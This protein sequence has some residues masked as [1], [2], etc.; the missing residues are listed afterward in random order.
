M[1]C[2]VDEFGIADEYSSEEI[3]S[4]NYILSLIT[5][6]LSKIAEL[7]EAVL[8]ELAA[9][10]EPS[11]YAHLATWRV[12][13]K[14]P[15]A[16]LNLRPQTSQG[17]PIETLHPVFATFLNDVRS[18]PLDKWAPANEANTASIGLCKAMADSFDN[19]TARR[20]KLKQ[21]L[22]SF[23]LHL[24]TEYYIPPTLP[25]ET[26]SVRVGLHLSAGVGKTVLLGEIKAEFETG[27]PYMQVSR[28]Y[29]ALVHYLK[30]QDQAS[31][32]VPCILLSVCGQ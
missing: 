16:I 8:I 5:N 28:S 30:D 17:L 12:W 18:M 1:C 19:E 20:T 6:L 31:D 14:K 25:Q 15:T 27:D 29:Q 32:G 26:H 2:P 11:A 10:P 9:F 21:L 13:Q 22:H 7:I 23:G 4:Y 24:Q 3:A